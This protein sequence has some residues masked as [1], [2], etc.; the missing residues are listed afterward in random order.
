M[1]L[2]AVTMLAYR[3]KPV[4]FP[5]KPDIEPF[6]KSNLILLAFS[7]LICFSLV[8]V[9]INLV[10]PPISPDSLQYHLAFPAVW[11][12]NGNLANPACIF[13]SMPMVFS[14]ALE[15]SAVS[16]YPINAQ[17]FFAWLMLPL[18]NAFLADIGELPFYLTGIM[19]IF[20][21]LRKYGIKSEMALLSGFLWALIPNIFKQLR[22]ASQIDVICAVLFLLMIYTILLLKEGFNFKNAILFGISVGLFLGTKIINIVWFAAAFPFFY[23]VFYKSSRV[24]KAQTAKI[25]LMLGSIAFMIFLF[26]GFTYLRNL[27]FAGNP[28]FPVD[29][30]ILGVTVFKGIVDNVVYKATIASGD[31][32]D[33]TRILFAEGLGVQLL[34]L[35]LPGMLVPFI[36]YR[37]IKKKAVPWG[38]YFVLFMVPVTMVVLYSF[39]INIYVVRYLFPLISIGLVTAV[40]FINLIPRGEKYFYPVSFICILVSAS[41]LAHRNE[42]VA[43]LALAAILFTAM[44]LFKKRLAAFYRRRIFNKALAAFLI[45]GALLLGYFNSKYDREEFERYPSTF[46]KRETWQIDIARGWQKLNELTKTGSRVAYTGRLEFY[47]LFGTRLKNTVKYVSVNEK[48]FAP[49]N[50]LDGLYR[51]VKD[52]SAWKENLKKERI[53]YLFI[54]LPFPE[55]RESEDPAKFPIEDEWALARPELFTQ[56]FKNSLAH[57]YKVKY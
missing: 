9:F 31:K 52:F 46:S 34:G 14:K 7:I 40:I 4:L 17:L 8:K 28:F 48:D 56:V 10:N 1:L 39:F 3:K 43:S 21:I 54:A 19:V 33:F 13:G 55:N 23:Y 26:G 50:K 45:L 38:E 35:I 2:L 12:K 5:A 32:F 57:I 53:G 37:Q 11:I 29:L 42:F 36:F 41:E 20:A 30:R 25:N 27:V 49:Y 16:F 51:K 24:F 47:P 44:V 18:R 22:T 6:I 15:T